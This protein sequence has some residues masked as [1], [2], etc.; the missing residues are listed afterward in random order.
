M[1]GLSLRQRLLRLSMY[2][3]IGLSFIFASLA[4]VPDWTMLVFVQANNNLANFAVK[5]FSDMALVGSNA[6]VNLLVQ[7]YQTG[8][9]GIWR[10]K[11]E[12]EKMILDEC[13]QAAETDGSKAADLVG[14]MRWAVTKYPARNYSLVLWDH[15]IGIL[16]P[17]WGAQGRQRGGYERIDM[18]EAM[19]A[20][21]PRIQIAGLTTDAES[22]LTLEQRLDM[23][24]TSTRGILFNEHSRTYMD[25]QN[26]AS[27]LH[28]IKTQVLNNRKIDLLGMD[29]CL[30]A[31]VEVGY[32]ARDCVHYMVGSQEVELG[33]GWNYHALSA[34]LSHEAL[35]PLQLAQSIVHV[36]EAFYQPKVQFYTQSAVDLDQ[37]KMLKDSIDQVVRAVGVC[38]QS[39]RAAIG[40]A[41]RKARQACLQFSAVNYIDLYSFY[42]ELLKTVDARVTGATRGVADLKNAIRQ[43]M[44]MIEH[45]VVANA[46]GKNLDRAHGLSIYYPQGRIDASYVKT[47]FANECLWTTMIRELY[48]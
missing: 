36:Y 45:A 10:Y 23:S 35:S 18:D 31:M 13:F 17:I 34:S 1:K 3:L 6:K 29:A 2:C 11:I 8:R 37:I 30:M 24:Y 22:T 5:N 33:Y 46:A 9:K 47:E 26:L 41:L 14:A 38:K 42:T 39:D 4:A 21:N 25:N 16:D 44:A 20:S 15:G 19:V 40:D 43:S 27:A 32:L 12:K 28:T 7:W 48:G